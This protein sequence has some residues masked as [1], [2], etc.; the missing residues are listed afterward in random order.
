[1]QKL[2]QTE[3]KFFIW[4]NNLDAH[5]RLY[6]TLAV[7]LLVWIATTLKVTFPINLL[8]TW[9]AYAGCS[10]FFAWITIFSSHPKEVR[11]IASRQDS[12]RALVFLFVIGAALISLVAVLI[13]LKGTNG[14]SKSASH[15]HVLLSV[16]CVAISWWLVHTIFTLRYAHFYYCGT[17]RVGEL[18]DEPEGGLEFPGKLEPD[19]LDFAYFSFVIGMTF[20]VSDVEISSRR[21]RRLSLL[22]ALI[23]FV[24]NTVIL[25]LSINVIL[26]LVQK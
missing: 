3:V 24:F 7:A 15:L 11:K 21:I 25:A 2:K 16:A 8:L 9:L 18:A 5:H 19:Y 17:E 1:M 20:Q 26:G 14:L 12:S 4:I 10:L 13:L 22:H 23:S 6:I